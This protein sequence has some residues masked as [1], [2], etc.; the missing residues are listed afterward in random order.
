MWR[1]GVLAPGQVAVLD[2]SAPYVPPNPPND[3][4]VYATA[5]SNAL[6]TNGANDNV[7]LILSGR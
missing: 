3:P 6:D 1:I 7:A 2:A 5:R 4:V